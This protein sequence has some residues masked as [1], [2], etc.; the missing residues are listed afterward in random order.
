MILAWVS[1][2]LLAAGFVIAQER[3]RFL[4]T[5]PWPFITL[6]GAGFGI[7]VLGHLYGSK[8]LVGFGIFVVFVATLILPLAINLFELSRFC[9][10]P[11]VGAIRS[12]RGREAQGAVALPF[13]SGLSGRVWPIAPAAHATF[14]GQNG[15]LAFDQIR[16]LFLLFRATSDGI[17]TVDPHDGSRS[18]LRW[19]ASVRS[20]NSYRAGLRRGSKVPYDCG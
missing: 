4:H 5:S 18:R 8:I 13:W 7:G 9:G 16:P 20:L 14:P 19:A 15:K 10:R 3:G 6:F 2:A 11:E 1:T 12:V 17:W